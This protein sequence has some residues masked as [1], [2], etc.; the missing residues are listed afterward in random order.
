LGA[1]ALPLLLDA[2]FPRQ[3]AALLGDTPPAPSRVAARDLQPTTGAA[4]WP[5]PAR[6]LQPWL[7]LLVAALFLAERWLAT[8]RTRAPAP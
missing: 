7:A 8:R 3:L 6:D 4:P 1:G 2:D 5:Q